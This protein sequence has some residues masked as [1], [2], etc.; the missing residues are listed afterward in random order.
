MGEMTNGDMKAPSYDWKQEANHLRYEL[1]K[2][3]ALL[4][5][6]ENSADRLQTENDSLWDTLNTQGVDYGHLQSK[7]ENEI[8]LLREENQ[9]LKDD[10][11]K[12]KGAMDNIGHMHDPPTLTPAE[13]FGYLMACEDII[14]RARE[15][16]ANLKFKTEVKNE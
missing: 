16:L 3:R 4:F 11:E 14:K 2:T 15:T 13:Q 7:L 5:K 6:V 1:D 12:M 8:K 9:I 10:W